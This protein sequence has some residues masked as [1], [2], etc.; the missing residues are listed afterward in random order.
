MEVSNING[1]AIARQFTALAFAETEGFKRGGDNAALI[2][3]Y[4]IGAL[5]NESDTSRSR[6]QNR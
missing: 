5:K 6:K 1:A 4:T 3:F 2:V